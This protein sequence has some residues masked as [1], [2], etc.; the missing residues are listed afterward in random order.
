MPDSGSVPGHRPDLTLSRLREE[1]SADLTIRNLM[2]ALTLT[3]ELRARYR[4]FEFEAA[5]EGA[6]A[7]A[8]LFSRLSD[9]EG[10]QVRA[11]MHGLRERLGAAEH[12]AG[13]PAR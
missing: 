11:L 5:Q 12:A 8:E 7:S 10:E 3:Y 1:H 6:E 4:V 2:Q 13:G 9:R